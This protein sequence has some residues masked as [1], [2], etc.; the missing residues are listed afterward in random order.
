MTKSSPA[1]HFLLLLVIG[2]FP[3]MGCSKGED[4]WAHIE[5]SGVLRVGVDPTYPPFALAEDTGLRGIDVD[6]ARA[7][8]EELGLETQFFYFGYDGLYDAL[9]T[10]QVDV[11]ISALVILP[12]KTKDI[13]YS[14]PYFDS[15]LILIAPASGN[16]VAG[17]DDLNGKVIAVELGSIGHVKALELQ[18]NKGGFEIRTYDG[19]SE[20]MA[21]VSAREAHAALVDSVSGRLYIREQKLQGAPSLMIVGNHVTSEPFV[22][23]V[24]IEDRVLLTKMNEAIN[25]LSTND[26][27]KTIIEQHLD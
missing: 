23:A 24:R 10:D 21:A 18:G 27:L 1:I 3:L 17:I 15:G 16:Q 19:V 8:A 13:A 11:L 9:T 4:S 5:E 25:R 20:A 22:V 7:L 12:E 14:I 2:L 6:L 26:K